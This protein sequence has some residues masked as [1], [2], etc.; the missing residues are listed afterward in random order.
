MN[1][2]NKIQGEK[3]MYCDKCGTKKENGKCPKCDLGKTVSNAIHNLYV[4]VGTVAS[5]IIIRLL[6][7]QKI[8]TPSTTSWISGAMR[9]EYQVPNNIKGVMAVILVGSV[10]VLSG[11]FSSGKYNKPNTMFYLILEIIIGY[12]AITLV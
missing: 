6:T 7:Q 4:F 5:L 9:V 12:Y 1:A 10:F 3:V 11:M 8:E 2:Q